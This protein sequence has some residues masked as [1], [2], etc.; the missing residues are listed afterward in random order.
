VYALHHF[1]THEG[2]ARDDTV[3]GNHFTEVLGSKGTG[4]DVMITKRTFEAD[5]E[6]RVLVDVRV[7]QSTKRESRVFKSAVERGKKVRWLIEDTA[8]S[9]IF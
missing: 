1:G 7:L 6:N 9:R 5:V 8:V 3:E 2:T 4:I